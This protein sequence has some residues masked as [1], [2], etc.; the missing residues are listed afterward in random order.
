MPRRNHRSKKNR[1][2]HLPPVVKP[3]GKKRPRAFHRGPLQD[4]RYA[5]VE[6]R[7]RLAEEGLA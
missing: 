5:E 3:S 2:R 7:F 4:E 6:R 1:R